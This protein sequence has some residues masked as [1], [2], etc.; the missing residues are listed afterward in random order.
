MNKQ[1]MISVIVSN[2]TTEGKL[3]R[4]INS[5]IKQTYKN[6]EILAIIKKTEDKLKKIL[7]GYRRDYSFIKI[8]DTQKDDLEGKVYAIEKSKGEYFTFLNGSDYLGVDY[9]RVIV[10][11]ISETKADIIAADSMDVLE[12]NEGLYYPHNMLNQIKWKLKGSEAIDLLIG[13]RGLD[14]AWIHLWNKVYAKELWNKTKDLLKWIEGGDKTV[15]YEE[16]LLSATLF[17]KAEYV[18]NVHH[19]YYFHEKNKSKEEKKK[20]SID[21]VLK[22][23]EQ[24][25]EGFN[26]LEMILKNGD[27]WSRNSRNWERWR[28]Y[29][30]L[31]LIERVE[32]DN[33]LKPEE[34]KHLKDRLEKLINQEEIEPCDFDRNFCGRGVKWKYFEL[35]NMIKEAIAS[36]ECQ[37]VSFDVFDTLL[38]RPFFSP[39]DLFHLLDCYINELVPSTDYLVFTNIRIRAEELARTRK[40]IDDPSWEDVTLDEIYTE[41]EKI[42]PKLKPFIPTIKEKEIALELKYCNARESGKELVEC[43]IAC[44]KRVICTSDMYLPTDVIKKLLKNSGYEGIDYVYA[45]CDIGLTKGSGNLFD[46]VIKKEKVDSPINIVHIGDNWISDVENAKAKKIKSFHLPKTIDMFCNLNTG[47]YSGKYFYR[48]FN[49]QKGYVS[50]NAAMEMWG[51]R[52]MLAV[53]ANKI[54]DN[55]FVFFDFDSDFNADAYFIG[56]LGLGMHTYAIADWLLHETEKNKYSNLNF[57]ARDGYLPFN[58]FQSLNSIYNLETKTYYLWLSRKAILPLMVKNEIDFYG[59]YNTFNLGSLSPKK[60]LKIVTPIVDKTKVKVAEEIC[61]QYKIPFGRNFGTIE[62]LMDFA[63]LFFS[64]FYSKEL[65]EEYRTKFAAFLD[66]KFSGKS[67]TF[68]IGYSGRCESILQKNFGYDITAHYIH[69]TNDRSFGRADKSGIEIETLYPASPFISAIIREQFMSEMSPSCLEYGT[70][71]QS[72]CFEPVF[73]KKYEI[74]IQT[75]FVTNTMQ[76]AALEFVDDMVK[77]FGTDIKYLA[78]RYCDACLPFEYYL[79]YSSDA[80]KSLFRGTLFEDDMGMGNHKSFADFW[81]QELNRWGADTKTIVRRV[82]INYDSYPFFKR[83]CLIIGADWGEGKRRIAKKLSSKPLLLN[84]LRKSYHI[85]R[86]IYRIRK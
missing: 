8:L 71:A 3:H 83:W 16:L 15:F 18:T 39:T 55:P 65:A 33:D 56:Y 79:H 27:N 63:G 76:Q 72:G 26:S 10:K 66:T 73:E 44:G 5:L 11:E 60:F 58:A 21:L 31:Q 54:F 29:E 37:V 28:E 34:K 74:N 61:K 48:I 43:A 25:K 40:R 20:S 85:S 36:E 64:E 2:L 69:I 68:D 13:Q 78:Y 30:F 53:V 47:I 7:E 84:L 45:S 82:E 1:P 19:N 6:I 70:N 46:Y 59:L 35:Y 50:S 38:M 80:D 51:F 42:C 14:E 4:C 9:L 23:K 17:S 57:M 67:A 77:I 86:K 49:E 12:D 62:S 75:W 52:C 24:I 22:E 81:D 41:V 32:C